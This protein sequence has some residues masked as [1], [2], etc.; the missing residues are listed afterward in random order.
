MSPH[1]LLLNH[2]HHSAPPSAG[3][4]AATAPQG[5]ET[6][7][8]AYSSAVVSVVRKLGPS[9]VSLQ[10]QRGGTTEGES[11]QP[12]APPRRAPHPNAP[13][14]RPRAPH[15]RFGS[16][17]GFL[18]TPDGYLLTNSHVIH[19]ATR[20]TAVLHDGR[21]LD[22]EL[23]GDDPATDLAVVRV[24]DRGP[25]DHE[26]GRRFVPAEL[27]DSS[28]L[29]VGQ[30]AVAIGSPYGFQATVTAGVVSGLGRTFRTQSGRLIDEIIQTDASLNP[31]NSGGPL[32]D[33][34]GRVI[35]VNT[36]VIL[37]A[38]GICLAIPVNTARW[39]ATRLI[40]HGKVRRSALGVAAQNVR[41]DPRSAARHGL[42]ERNADSRSPVLR[43]GV[44]VTGIEPRTAASRSDLREGDVIVGLEEHVVRHV[45]DLHKLLD[46]TRI[47]VSTALLV[48]R[49][50]A[51]TT[52]IVVPE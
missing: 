4:P 5:D 44:M 35:G 23:V 41:I 22:A 31:G 10:V 8:D 18:F 16:G 38:Q 2:A 1:V 48:L 50:E 36:S 12:S 32:A 45:D 34:R 7:L 30:L 14:R 3:E 26:A 13:P 21:R 15:G 37:P 20:I 29:A 40:A 9:V 39:V 49:G 6:L 46:E 25:D 51:L 28:T 11:V 42:R 27:G 43:S 47:G 17:S 52:A 33:S 19:A 24:R